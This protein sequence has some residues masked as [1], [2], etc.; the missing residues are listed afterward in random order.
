VLQSQSGYWVEVASQGAIVNL[1]VGDANETAILSVKANSS[2][3]SSMH[4]YMFVF[5]M[6]G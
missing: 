2:L 4:L 1:E 3:F 5:S 6:I